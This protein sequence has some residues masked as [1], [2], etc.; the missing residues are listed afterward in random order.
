MAISMW[1]TKSGKLAAN[2]SGIP[3]IATRD[4]L[5][6]CCCKPCVCPC[7][8]WPPESWPC[9]GLIEQYVADNGYT[10]PI[11]STSILYYQELYGN[12]D[13]S[14]NPLAWRE[15]RLTR[16]LTMTADLT[17]SCRWTGN[18]YGKLQMRE[19]L[20]P[21][22]EDVEYPEDFIIELDL[23]TCFWTFQMRIGFDPSGKDMG[24]TP[25]GHYRIL[26]E[27]ATNEGVCDGF[28]TK[29]WKG[30]DVWGSAPLSCPCGDWLPE[31]WPCN[32][33]QE[34][35]LATFEWTRWY[36][37][38]PGCPE[39]DSSSGGGYVLTGTDSAVLTATS[40]PCTWSGVVEGWES[41]PT[42]LFE[43][44]VYLDS[45]LWKYSVNFDG[46]IGTGSR[47]GPVPEGLYS[48]YFGPCVSDSGGGSGYF[49][50]EFL[51]V[52]PWP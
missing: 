52:D 17:S 51:D 19:T 8:D 36:F 43:V 35:Y 23:T 3:F 47:I 10:S 49:K 42:E 50:V 37:P 1:L 4:E 5:E 12:P 24:S 33:L 2:A 18:P 27:Q 29:H 14:G 7:E 44:T 11:D 13:C 22:W 46:N 20:Y 28:G 41:N 9:G 34:Q 38:S 32:G 39:G 45:G 25:A 16:A 21:D 40:Q 30:I 15:W 6:N 26:A 48:D 31:S